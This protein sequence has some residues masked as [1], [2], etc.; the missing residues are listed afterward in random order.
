MNSPQTINKIIVVGILTIAISI[1][2]VIAFVSGD[3]KELVT[4]LSNVISGLIG[5]LG[6]SVAHA[7][8]SVEK[9]TT[10]SSTSSGDV[11]NVAPV[12]PAKEEN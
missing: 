12:N 8:S 4:I 11:I 9:P 5:F 10:G 2:G 1:I 3:H 6:S 7:F